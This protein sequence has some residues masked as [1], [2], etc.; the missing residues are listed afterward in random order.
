MDEYWQDQRERLLEEVAAPLILCGD[1]RNDSPGYSAQYCTYSLMDITSNKIVALEVVDSREAN[2][3]SV[4]M[5]K[6]GFTRAMDDVISKSAT[7]ITEVVTDQ[8]I[9]ITAVM[10]EY[11]ILYLNIIIL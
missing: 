10:S 2:D 6:L 1:G 11:M 9:Q 3:K 5:E 7:P 4:N 8:H